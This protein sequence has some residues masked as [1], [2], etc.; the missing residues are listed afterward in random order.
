MLIKEFESDKMVEITE[1]LNVIKRVYLSG[2]WVD[3]TLWITFSLS[4][5]VDQEE[6]PNTESAQFAN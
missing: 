4:F 3:Q 6:H 2:L 1:L 5:S